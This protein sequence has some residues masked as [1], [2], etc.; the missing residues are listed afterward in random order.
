MGKRCG[1]TGDGRARDRITSCRRSPAAVL[2][3]LAWRD[4]PLS[5]WFPVMTHAQKAKWM[6]AL[7]GMKVTEIGRQERQTAR[8]RACKSWPA[9]STELDDDDRRF[10]VTWF[11]FYSIVPETFEIAAQLC[12]P[13]SAAEAELD[14][15][16]EDA[17]PEPEASEPA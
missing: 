10:L 3:V 9:A 15:L 12:E 8:R 6:S 13:G 11:G 2:K 7:C 17:R 5:E 16:F 14:E 1:R 4:A